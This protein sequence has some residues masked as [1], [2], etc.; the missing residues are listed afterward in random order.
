MRTQ[1]LA[2]KTDGT[3]A[4]VDVIASVKVSGYIFLVHPSLNHPNQYSATYA[5]IG[6]GITQ[7]SSIEAVIE[8]LEKYADRVDAAIK[9]RLKLMADSMIPLMA[10]ECGIIVDGWQARE[11]QRFDDGD[12]SPVPSIHGMI[13]PKGHYVHL[14]TTKTESDFV[15]YTPNEAYGIADRQ[16]RLKFGKYLKK[17]FPSMSDAAIQSAVV[18]LRA[19]LEILE[20]PAI[21]KFATDRD[22]IS[23]I[24]ET[25]MYACD[26]SCSSCMFD[27]FTDREIRPYHVYADSPDVAVAYL[28]EQGNI[29][30]R[31]VVSTKDKEWVRAYS[32]RANDSTLCAVLTSMLESQGYTEGDL[33]GNRLTKLPKHRNGHV[34]PYIDHGGMGLISEGKY[35]EV[36][37][38]RDGEYI[39]DNTDGTL[40]DNKPRCADCENPEDE[41]EC[42]YCE[43]CDE[44][45]YHGCDNCNMCPE[46]DRCIEHERCQCERCGDCREIISPNSRHA[47][48]CDCDRCGECGELESDCDCSLCDECGRLSEDCECEPEEETIEETEVTA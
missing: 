38:D 1:C 37:N 21:V 35:W 45:F 7:Y 41:C 44:S 4:L 43:C 26:S 14:S 30:A 47:T 6:I 12:Y 34:A 3:Y 32:I 19:K 11:Q 29:T 16:V 27:K 39:A 24:F 36:C 10:P 22:T 25:E 18:A 2:L 46:C 31:S 42:I 40:S 9:S 17:T 28:L 23:A 8:G 5:P 13:Y 20:S 15:A 33:I 48:R